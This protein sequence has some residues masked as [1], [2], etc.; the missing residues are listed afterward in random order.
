MKGYEE[1]MITIMTALKKA[2]LFG[3]FIFE[4]TERA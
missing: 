2:D 4:K 3:N 1:G